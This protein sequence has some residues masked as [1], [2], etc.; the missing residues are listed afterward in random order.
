MT[1]QK[2]FLDLNTQEVSVADLNRGVIVVS[3][4]DAAVALAEY[5]FRQCAELC[6]NNE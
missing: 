1:Y 6:R 4:N 3:G 2:C 5:I